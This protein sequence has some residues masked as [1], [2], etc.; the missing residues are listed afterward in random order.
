MNY[1]ER[2]ILGIIQKVYKAKYTGTLEVKRL[3]SGYKVEFGLG[4]DT[5]KP[6]QIAADLE[7][8]D[9]LKFIEQE[10]KSRQLIKVQ[11]FTGY[12]YEP[13]DE[14]RTTCRENR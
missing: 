4:S 3:K 12:K 7:A 14:K 1:M 11:Y 5:I 10:L 8:E 13:G 6:L 9:F 2:A